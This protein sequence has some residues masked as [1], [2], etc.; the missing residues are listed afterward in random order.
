MASDREQLRQLT[1]DVR[2]PPEAERELAAMPADA[3]CD[4]VLD[5]DEP[6]W[7]RR[8]CVRALAGR[9]PAG[10]AGDLLACV[11][12]AKVTT[13]V[14]IELLDVLS[15]ED[16]PHADALL[17][18]LRAKE[19]VPQPYRF[20]PALLHARAQ[21]GDLTVAAAVVELE[22]DAWPH[23]RRTGTSAVDT[24]IEVCGMEAVLSELG[25]ASTRALVTHGRTAAARVTG[26]RLCWENREDFTAALADD[27][28]AVARAAYDLLATYEPDEEN[29]REHE[30]HAMVEQRL[31]GHQW[32]LAILAR[33]GHDI[34]PQWEALGRPRVEL[35][36]VPADVREAILREYAPGQRDTDPR[37]LLEAACLPPR[38]EP[39][40]AELLRQAK[41][42]LDQAGLAPETPVSAGDLHQQGDGT[43]YMIGTLAGTVVVSTLGRFFRESLAEDGADAR[44]LDALRA[45]GFRYIDAD[46]A[47]VRFEG[48]P[49]YHFGARQPLSVSDLLFYW[50][51]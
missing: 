14:R 19:G 34:E 3:L 24:L 41:D 23:I 21:L 12:D 26:I 39:G 9:V 6:W 47:D 42:A 1:S 37:W 40:E 51:D 20:E 45:N 44:A 46:L 30:L 32:A 48:L 2:I 18:W 49:V 43:Y 38:P 10:R 17:G 36:G 7:R 50:Q 35:P 33:R 22:G 8:L 27:S 15:T 31:P 16:S 13:E 11:Q 29:S 4:L 25:V 5:R 28:F